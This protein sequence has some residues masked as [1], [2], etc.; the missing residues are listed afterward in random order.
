M[1]LQTATFC[2]FSGLNI[3]SLYLY[4][5]YCKYCCY[6]QCSA[7]I[8]LNYSFHFFQIYI[9]R[10]EI[11]A[12]LVVQLVKNLHATQEN[13]DWFLG[14]EDLLEKGEATYSSILGLPWWFKQKRICLQCGRAGLIPGLGRSRRGG[15]GNPLQYSCLEN[16]HG[17]RGAWRAAVH[18][19]TESPTQLSNQAEPSTR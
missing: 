18:E 13:L 14:W 12:S 17:Q 10:S 15:H 4:P 5:D 6:E 1:L 2:S 7:C 11:A 16:S 3:T 9:T 8:F 19:V